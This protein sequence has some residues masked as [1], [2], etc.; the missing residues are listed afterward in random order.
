MPI[1]ALNL[2]P[3]GYKLKSEAISKATAELRKNVTQAEQCSKECADFL[4]ECINYLAEYRSWLLQ[5]LQR[6]TEE[7]RS[8]VE[9]AIQE[10]NFCLEQGVEPAYPLAVA[11]WTLSCEELHVFRYT[12]THP[13]L[14]S[15]CGTWVSYQNDLKTLCEGFPARPSQRR[16]EVKEP[17]VKPVPPIA[18]ASDDI[19]AAVFENTVELYQL[20]TQQ[21]TQKDLPVNFGHECSY[22]AIDK[23]T[24][25]CIGAF[26]DYK[27]VYQL[28]VPSLQ[29]TFLPSLRSPREAAGV[30][31]TSQFVYV[32]GGIPCKESCEKYSLTEKTSLPLSSIMRYGR[33][34]FTPCSLWALIYLPCPFT[35]PIIESF[36]PGTEVF[37]ELPVSLPRHMKDLFSVAF[38]AQGEL[39]VLTE[40]KLMAVWKIESESSFRL[41]HVDRECASTQPPLIAGSLVLIAYHGNVM[42]FSLESYSF[43]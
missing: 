27:S 37:T 5:K 22:I 12:V 40:N 23:H 13:D 21:S 30:A 26:P 3:E 9:Q 42:K 7:M 36:N 16:E 32:F 18:A 43:V 1:G 24:L 8:A 31:K 2:G 14:P 19:F 38:I 11:A 29:L 20:N 15:L 35:T 4:Q 25:L 34:Y 17:F 10:V 33:C 41:S 39:H 6:D 28:E